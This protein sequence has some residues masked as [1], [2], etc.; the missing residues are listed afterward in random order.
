MIVDIRFNTNYPD[1]S[2]FEWRVLTDGHETLVNAVRCNVPTYTTS[3]FIKEVGMKWHMS[4]KANDVIYTE[5][6]G[7]KIAEI[8]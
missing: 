8:V 6:A 5:F 4:A 3:T 7:L 1:N 2:K